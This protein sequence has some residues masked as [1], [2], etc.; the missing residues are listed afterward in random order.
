MKTYSFL[1]AFVLLSTCSF[2]QVTAQTNIPSSIAPNSDLVIEVKLNKGSITNFAK[3]QIDVPAGVTVTEGDT[4]SGNFTFDGTRAKIVWVSIPTEPE[5]IV[6]FRMNT[7]SASGAGVF[8]HKFYYLG[9]GGKKEVEFDAVN[10]TFEA[11]GAK[12]A[13]SLGGAALSAVANTNPSGSQ[14]TSPSKENVTSNSNSNS[15][16]SY[17]EPVKTN[18]EPVKTNAEPVK[19][20]VTKSSEPVKTTPK[21]TTPVAK[22][23]NTSPKV[24]EPKAAKTTENTASSGNLVFKVQIGAYGEDPAKSLFKGISDKVTVVKD[25]GFYKALV[26]NFNSKEEALTKINELKSSGIQGFVVKYQNGVRVK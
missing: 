24:S 21:E 15:N 25:G 8:T 17:S 11:S 4:K 23:E 10:T 9:E 13:K 20:V 1:L 26:G 14:S 19:D 5:F 18:T 12:S 22:T 3:Y 16:S 7:G 6:S 2:S